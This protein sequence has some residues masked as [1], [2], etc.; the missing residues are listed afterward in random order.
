VKTE[1]ADP[2][3]PQRTSPVGQLKPNDLGLFDMYGNVWEWTQDRVARHSRGDVRED[4]EDGALRISDVEARTRR[5]GAFPY[6]AAMERSAERGTIGSLP[7]TR[8][9]N[10][11][12]R[13]ARSMP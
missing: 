5:G 1:P 11:G 9:D 4:R 2:L 10:V 7:A 12:F 6:E 3:D 8:R 13:I